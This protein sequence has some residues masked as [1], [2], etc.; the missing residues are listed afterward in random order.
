LTTFELR[1]M[2][3]ARCLASAP[4]LVLLDEPLA[5]LSS[6]GVGVMTE[7]IR[8]IRGEGTTVAIIEHTMQAVLRLADRLV[9]LDQGRRIAAGAPSE[10]TRDPRVIEAYLGKRWL[11]HVDSLRA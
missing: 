10:V 8:R 11:R 4:A 6:D 7:L 5:G 1:L 2:E 9:V 3:L